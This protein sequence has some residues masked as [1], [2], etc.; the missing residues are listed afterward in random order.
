MK[1]EFSKNAREEISTA[2]QW[3]EG[4]Q[5]GLGERFLE[6]LESKASFIQ[7]NPRAYPLKHDYLRLALI[8]KFP[9]LLVY[10]LAKGKVIIYHVF[11]TS[12]NPE[13]WKS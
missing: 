13:Y 3:Y 11:H 1:L 2:Y 12:R 7:N 4:Q 9:F 5:A 8:D 10:E 6:Y